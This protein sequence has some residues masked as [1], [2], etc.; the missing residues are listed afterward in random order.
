[1]A[2]TMLF[3]G[4]QTS[5]YCQCPEIGVA[6]SFGGPSNYAGSTVGYLGD[7]VVNYTDEGDCDIELLSLRNSL[8]RYVRGTPV[9]RARSGLLQRGL[10]V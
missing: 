9:G 10:R 5:H 4:Y 6:V 8:W 3:E 7:Y 1:M 2:S